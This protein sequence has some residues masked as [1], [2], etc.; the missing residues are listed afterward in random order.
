[1]CAKKA[2]S[3]PAKKSAAK[4]SGKPVA[5]PSENG[6]P[7]TPSPAPAAKS[8]TKQLSAKT[9]PLKARAKVTAERSLSSHDI[10]VVAGEVWQLLS[11]S[12]PQTLASVKKTVKA[13]AEVVAAAIGWLARED[14]LEF[15]GG[16]SVRL[17]LK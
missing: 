8:V 9:V 1:M 14:K 3:A 15:T 4:A 10:G 12:G 7:A 17:S 6:Q 11:D 5:K 16:K 13:P 2:T